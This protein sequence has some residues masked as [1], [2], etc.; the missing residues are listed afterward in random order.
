[1]VQRAAWCSLE[2][3]D[4]LNNFQPAKDNPDLKLTLHTGVGAGDLLGIFVGGTNGMWEFF[5]AGEPIHQMAEAGEEAKSGEVML[6]SYCHKLV[7]K[8]V[9]GE[10]KKSG[11]F[12][13]K[14]IPTKPFLPKF[15]PMPV[16]NE[17][18]DVLQAFIPPMVRKSLE[19][20]SSAAWLSEFRRVC[21]M[22]V[23]LPGLDYTKDDVLE[24]LQA[25]VCAVQETVLKYDGTVARLLCDDKGTRF[26]IAFGMPSMF[27]EDDAV[28]VILAGLEIQKRLRVITPPAIGIA[29]GTVYCGEAGSSR[30][31]EY[32]A[33]GFKVNMAARLMQVAGQTGGGVLCEEDTMKLAEKSVVFEARDPVKLK[34]LGFVCLFVWLVVFSLLSWLFCLS[35][36]L[37]V[38]FPFPLLQSLILLPFLVLSRA[39]FRALSLPSFLPSFLLPS[40]FLPPSSLPPSPSLRYRKQSPYFPSSRPFSR[41]QDDEQQDHQDA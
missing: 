29:T 12:L 37:F 20:G 13:I 8:Y 32:T 30:R 35:V 18:E 14:A 36:C 3:L 24:K 11:N 33:V 19:G 25:A 31:C 21:V 40:S 17:L 23:A 15:D 38:F 4:K 27:H 9:E 41:H 1:L 5:I 10:K 16:P 7:E 28:R 6:S 2:L 26:K 34:G 39:L 22:F